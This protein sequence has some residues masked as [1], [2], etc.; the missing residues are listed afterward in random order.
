MSTFAEKLRPASFRGVPFS[1]TESTFTVGRRIHVFEYPQRDKPFVEDLGKSAREITVTAVFAGADYISG[2][3][4]LL[5][6][7]EQE[8]SGVLIHPMLGSMKVTP[9]ESTKVT[10]STKDCGYSFATLT[11]VESGDYVYPTSVVDTAAKVAAAA[12]GLNAAALQAFIKRLDLTGAQDFVISTIGGRLSEYF[13]IDVYKTIS[14]L[15]DVSDEMSTLAARAISYVN[16]TPRSFGQAVLNAFGFSRASYSVNNWRRVTRLLSLLVKSDGMNNSYAV[17]RKSAES[18][19]ATAASL[20]VQALA[21]SAVLAEAISA[22]ANVGGSEGGISYED[23]ISI[24]DEVLGAIDAEM[25]KCEDDDVYL[26]LEESRA[27]VYDD[28]TSRAQDEARLITVT[29]PEVMPALVVAYDFYEDA[30]RDQE[31]IDR[32]G[33]R[34]GGFVPAKELLLLSR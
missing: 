12:S 9:K 24:R 31:I 10:Y 32:N 13:Q 7:M 1:V 22:S 19:R 2:M 4:K 27:S 28:M 6:A 21:R 26:A 14:S 25:L 34:H 17:A 18:S 16:R 11:F 8:G 5:D 15:F 30:S 20:Q 33:V 29:P 23:M 3:Q